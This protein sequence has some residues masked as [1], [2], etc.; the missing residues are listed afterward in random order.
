M[1]Q[2]DGVKIAIAVL[3]IVGGLIGCYFGF[4]LGI[5]IGLRGA[6]GGQPVRTLRSPLHRPLGMLAGSGIAGW[7]C[8]RYLS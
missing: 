3:I 6:Q 1:P 8:K 5:F 7:F 2:G 4:L